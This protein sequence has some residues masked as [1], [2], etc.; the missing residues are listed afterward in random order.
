MESRN[1]LAAAYRDT[2]R[3]G[4]ARKLNPAFRNCT[5]CTNCTAMI[6]RRR[7]RRVGARLFRRLRAVGCPVIVN[8]QSV[9]LYFLCIAALGV[10]VRFCRRGGDSQNSRGL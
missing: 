5:N 9:D 4:E 6:T 1:S 7:M 10:N 8:A 3:T 2:G